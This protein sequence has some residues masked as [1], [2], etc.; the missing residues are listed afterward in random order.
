MH[1]RPRPADRPALRRS[2]VRFALALAVAWTAVVAASLAWNLARQAEWSLESAR[3]HARTALEKDVLYRRWAAWTGGVY[4]PRS[5]RTPPNPF[6]DHANRDVVTADGLALTLINPAYMTRQVYDLAGERAGLQSRITCLTPLRAQNR[7]DSWEA[8]ALTAFQRGETEANS[9]ESL[10]GVPHLRVMRP[11]EA[12]E[13][14]RHCH[15]G[16]DEDERSTHGG[17]SV[18]VNLLPYRVGHRGAVAGLVG[19]HG[20]LWLLGLG[21][22][23]W[24][25][26][27]LVHGQRA[28]DRATRA[29]AESEARFQMLFHQAPLG[30]QS[31][32]AEG[33]VLEVNDTWLRLTGYA[34]D[35]VV[36]RPF[37]EFLGD[38]AR[39]AFPDNFARFRE[40]GE[41]HDLTYPL[42]R[43][44]GTPLW[45]ALHGRWA[46]TSRGGSSRPTAS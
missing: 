41:V 9:V 21:G 20:L 29:L 22:L 36:G 25:T 13:G 23:G 31:L 42:R 45:V 27:R 7:P 40:Q 35:Q 12:E 32:D 14:C 11:L 39:A 24:G 5:E 19:A 15:P 2:P 33:R 28:R 26:R 44:D 46:A 16:A 43:H 1:D 10:D 8:A 38:G 17:L 34:R 4:V 3:I 6:L 37:A 18:A 30:Y